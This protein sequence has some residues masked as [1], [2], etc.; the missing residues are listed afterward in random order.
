MQIS[1]TK[2]DK[3]NKVGL[4]LRDW[5]KKQSDFWSYFIQ[6]L[7]FIFFF[8]KQLDSLSQTGDK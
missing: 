6:S 8:E 3:G 2:G 4:L 5:A 1:P 7:V